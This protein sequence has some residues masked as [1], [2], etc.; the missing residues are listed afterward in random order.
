VV[1]GAIGVRH[2]FI[3]ASEPVA[4]G[5]VVITTNPSSVPITIDGQPNG[6]TPVTVTLNAGAHILE[7]LGANE[8]RTIPLSVTAGTRVSQY[9]ELRRTEVRTG[10]FE[11]R[12]EPAG[13]NVTID[14]Q[15]RGTSPLTIDDLTPGAHTVSV[16]NGLRSLSQEV[17][18]QAGVTKSLI[19]SLSGPSRD[20]P[21]SG[22]VSL[23]T[24]VDTQ[25]YE[26]GRLIGNSRIDRIM[27]PAGRHDVEIVNE[28]L[29]YRV[30]YSVEVVPGKVSPIK[31]EWPKGTISLN[32]LPWADVW[33]DGEKIG[34]TPIGNLGLPIG[35][36]E[37]VFRHPELGERTYAISTMASTPTR[38][39]VDMTKK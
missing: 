30:K 17:T 6:S 12:T 19:M 15:L 23:T 26:S 38:V 2:Y 20:A 13:A 31:L 37:I 9:I 29:Q 8:P 11:V 33:L 1:G 21:V 10:Q 24:P 39:T 18:I 22:W 25:L 16:E 35:P 34:E 3:A 14:G 7:L 5:T 27:M 32:A 4:T 36:H 28:T